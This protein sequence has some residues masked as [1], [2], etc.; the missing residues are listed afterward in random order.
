M[1]FKKTGERISYEDSFFFDIQTFKSVISM[2]D[3]PLTVGN[4]KGDDEALYSKS[5]SKSAI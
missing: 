1:N 4:T 5:P 2:K 3:L